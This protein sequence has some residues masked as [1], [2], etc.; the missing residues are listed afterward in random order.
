MGGG[1]IA[2][3]LR[4]PADPLLLID[5]RLVLALIDRA[6]PGVSRELANAAARPIERA[7]VLRPVK[8]KP[9][10]WPRRRG[11]P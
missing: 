7:A 4:P 3:P 9:F 1:R 11:Q 2:V 5:C 8:A 10:G 6:G